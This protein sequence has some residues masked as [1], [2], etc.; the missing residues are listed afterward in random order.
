MDKNTEGLDYLTWNMFDSPD[1]DG[2][3]YKYMEKEPVVILDRVIHKTKLLAEIEVGYASPEYA[4]ALDLEEDNSHRIGKGIRFKC[5]YK[6]SRLLFVKELMNLGV[7]RI[8][9]S[10]RSIY[11]DTDNSFKPPVLEIVRKF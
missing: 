9:L 7:Q 6:K 11:F 4:R 5:I 8:Q 10:D 2:S 3:G 1:Q